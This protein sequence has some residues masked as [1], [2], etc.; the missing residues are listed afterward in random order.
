MKIALCFIVSYNNT[1]LKQDI[2]KKWIEQNKDIINVYFHPDPYK[3]I[4][5]PWVRKHIIH[6]KKI[7]RTS[8]YHVVPAYI[9]LLRE[10]LHYVDN[11]WFCFLTDSCVPIIP[12]KRFRELFEKY[13]DN[14]IMSWRKAW[15]NP[16]F[17]KRANLSKLSNEFRL[18]NAPWFVLTRCHAIKIARFPILNY[19]IY[20]TICR[21]GLANESIFAIIL[22]FTKDL[23]L[24]VINQ[25]SHLTD[26]TEMSSATSPYIFKT[27]NQREIN[28]I[29]AIMK[30]NPCIMFMRKISTTFPDHILKKFL[31]I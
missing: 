17:Q 25:D 5:D 16:Y 27:G 12:P 15:W 21:G 2:W 18:G 8:Y 20:E 6:P 10:A 24:N 13:A 26:W 23:E 4:H 31:N 1:L 28:K 30:E 3:P 14:S 9:Q 11:K 22:K 19:S 29:H 7:V